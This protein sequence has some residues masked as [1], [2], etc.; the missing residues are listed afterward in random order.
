M[1]TLLISL[2][3]AAV[4]CLPAGAIELPDGLDAVVPQELRKTAVWKIPNLCW[5]IS[6][7]G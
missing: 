4:L 2:L 5:N 6:S 3:A 1:K 7:T